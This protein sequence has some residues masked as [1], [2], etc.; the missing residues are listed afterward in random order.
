MASTSVQ[1]RKGRCSRS[2]S[3]GTEGTSTQG[4]NRS[5]SDSAGTEEAN[6]SKRSKIHVAY[7][8]PHLSSI[9]ITINLNIF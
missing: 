2:G 6:T 8:T 4:R 7:S 1:G 5:W 3:A 9:Y